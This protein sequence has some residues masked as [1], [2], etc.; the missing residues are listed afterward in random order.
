VRAAAQGLL[1]VDEGCPTTWRYLLK[2][3]MT[4]QEIQ[5][6]DSISLCQSMVQYH[7]SGAQVLTASPGNEFKWNLYEMCRDQGLLVYQK[8]GLLTSPWDESWKKD[9]EKTEKRL[10]DS[11]SE[12]ANTGITDEGVVKMIREYEVFKK[13]QGEKV[14]EAVDD[15]PAG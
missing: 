1:D 2:E 7:A 10:R 15:E 11:H 12:I 9:I 8:L 13:T 3:V 4:L 6:A 14:V 5:R